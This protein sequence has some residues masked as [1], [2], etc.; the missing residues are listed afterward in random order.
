MLRLNSLS[1]DDS[2][3]EQL[4][5][6]IGTRI[7]VNLKKIKLFTNH[8]S[9]SG[10]SAITSSISTLTVPNLEML[11]FGENWMGDTGARSLAVM[12]ASGGTPKLRHLD[13]RKSQISNEG[14]RAVADAIT[15]HTTPALEK[16]TARKNLDQDVDQDGEPLVIQR[17]L[18]TL[19]EWRALKVD[20]QRVD[21]EG[22][23]GEEGRLEC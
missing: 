10:V 19:L 20:V 9:G 4:A 5:K 2:H 18:D 3:A 13:I 15:S 23:G 22:L 7:F 12:L 16:V 8:F 17:A 11:L 14:L 6:V 1:W 21:L